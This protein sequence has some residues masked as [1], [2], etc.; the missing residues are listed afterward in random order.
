[1]ASRRQYKDDGQNR[2]NKENSTHRKTWMDGQPPPV[3]LIL[4]QHVSK[5]S[6]TRLCI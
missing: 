6:E 4:M 2:L 5:A 3:R 1:M